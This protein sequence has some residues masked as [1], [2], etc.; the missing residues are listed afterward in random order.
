M[1]INATLINIFHIC[2]REMWLHYHAIRMEHTSDI[3]A[4]GK[5]IGEES[6]PQRADKNEEVAVSYELPSR[7]SEG[8][9][10][11]EESVMLTAKIDFFDAKRTLG[12]SVSYKHLIKLECYKLQKHLLGIENYR[13]FRMM[14]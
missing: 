14:W 13:P 7:N 10:Q 1:N 4:E 12:R 2:H 3:V 8:Q 11:S 6:Y 9:G 5:L